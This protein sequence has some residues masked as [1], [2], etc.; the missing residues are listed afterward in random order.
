MRKGEILVFLLLAAS[1]LS[2]CAAA[3]LIPVVG[4][5]QVIPVIGVSYQ[6][7][8]VW[9]GRESS[10]YYAH[11]SKTVCQAV[12]QSCEQLKLETVIQN[13]ASENG[14]SLVTKGKYPMD[15]SASRTEEN[16]TKVVITIELF[17]DKQYAE[18]LYR[19]IDDNTHEKTEI[20]PITTDDIHKATTTDK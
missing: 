14:C 17:G 18:L 9:K 2:G 6:G 4:E 1:L 19:T 10:K 11:D 20:K 15:I 13:P 12:E 16:L 8:V 5:A 7:Y 3:P